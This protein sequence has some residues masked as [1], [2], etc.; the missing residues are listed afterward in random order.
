MN[1]NDNTDYNPAE[2]ENQGVITK[3]AQGAEANDS[4]SQLAYM[5]PIT[6]QGPEPE[7]EEVNESDQES[8]GINDDVLA[9]E[10]V[11]DGEITETEAD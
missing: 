3:L 2:D 1:P 5:N 9:E 11:A 4:V 6:N 7:K 8:G 10:D